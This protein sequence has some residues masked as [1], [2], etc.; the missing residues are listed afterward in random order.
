[1]SKQHILVIDSD[2]EIVDSLLGQLEQYGLEG[3]PVTSLEQAVRMVK[4]QVP[5]VIIM[6]SGFAQE[7][8]EYYF[9]LIKSVLPKGEKVPAL[10]VMSVTQDQ[11]LRTYA[12]E[13]GEEETPL[14]PFDA[15]SLKTLMAD[16]LPVDDL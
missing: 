15:D 8:G 2:P 4:E 12:Y 16:Y 13:M 11:N 6:D 9:H 10:R 14:R 1:M 7:E 5:D 3:C